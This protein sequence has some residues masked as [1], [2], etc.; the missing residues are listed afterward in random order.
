MKE[1]CLYEVYESF[2]DRYSVGTVY[3]EYGYHGQT[4]T[5]EMF[6][7]IRWERFTVAKLKFIGQCPESDVKMFMREYRDA[8]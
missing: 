7:E 1:V 6:N 3:I 4:W 2:H 8:Q 5:M